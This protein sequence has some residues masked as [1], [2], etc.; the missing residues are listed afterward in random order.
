MFTALSFPVHVTSPQNARAIGASSV[1]L[2]ASEYLANSRF[3]ATALVTSPQF[4]CQM[5]DMPSFTNA[6]KLNLSSDVRPKDAQA[7]SSAAEKRWGSTRPS[8]LMMSPSMKLIEPATE[9]A[10]DHCSKRSNHKDHAVQVIEEWQLNKCFFISLT[11]K[12]I[13]Q[14]IVSFSQCHIFQNR[15]S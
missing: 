12:Y 13:H 2:A 5:G 3:G 15:H 14:I 11:S 1:L 10:T 9:P 6:T 7:R 4:A 8:C